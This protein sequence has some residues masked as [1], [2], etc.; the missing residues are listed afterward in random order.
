MSY[1]NKT[2]L[3][4]VFTSLITREAVFKTKDYRFEYQKFENFEK[5]EKTEKKREKK[6]QLE[7]H[8]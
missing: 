4:F 6:R 1:F 5:F 8:G 3:L 7:N 2:A